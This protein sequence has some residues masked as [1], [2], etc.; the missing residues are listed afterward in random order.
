[1]RRR[2]LWLFAS[3]FLIISILLVSCGPKP[4]APAPAASTPAPITPAPVPAPTTT[5]AP[6]GLS[7]MAPS[8]QSE[9]PRYGGTINII[10]SLN[11]QIENWDSAAQPVGMTESSYLLHEQLIS[12]DW[13]KGPAGTGE[14]DWGSF[15]R[16]E[17]FGGQLAESWTIPQVGTWIFKIRKGVHYGL[18]PAS[19]ASKLVNGR[20]FTADDAVWGLRRYTTDPAY[21][22]ANV[23]RSQGVMAR[24]VTADKT[25]PW[26]VTLKTPVE[27][28]VAFFWVVWGGNSMHF[29]AREVI[30]K[31]GSGSDPRNAVGTGP[32]LVTDYIPGNMIAFTRNPNYWK[33]EP[34]G[35][36]K[37]MQLPYISTIKVFVVPDVSTRVAAMRTGKGDWV[38]AIEAEDAESLLKTSPELQYYRFLASGGGIA[39]RIEK[40]ELPFKDV[41]VRQ[42]LMMATDYETIKRDLYEG[43]AEILASP[44][45][46][47]Y[48]WLFVP[49]NKLSPNIQE[50]FKYNPEKAKQLLAEAGYPKGFKTK[51]LVRSTA[52]EMD[53]ASLIKAMWLKAGVDVE[54]QSRDATVYSSMGTA[55]SWEETQMGTFSSGGLMLTQIFSMGFK[56]T[57]IAGQ[58]IWEDP[59]ARKAYDEAQ[60]YVFVDMKK[61]DEI[62]RNIIPH[63]IEQATTIPLPVPY[64]YTIWQPWV[65]N[66]YGLSRFEYFSM[67]L[68]EAWIDQDLKEKMTGRR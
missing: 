21:P 15:Q 17:S 59:V 47:Y 29:F 60:K 41:K 26:E 12:P 27:P 19:E 43:Q 32:Y 54:I 35:P 36:G 1:M 45:P 64:S 11:S 18:N 51:M 28:W 5:P 39:M 68:Q 62:Q 66:V 53:K 3:L 58:T 61:Y 20:E 52:A 16:F 34:V 8:A 30:E 38:T 14:T 22:N 10:M 23:R 50:L 4:V 9:K 48:D 25:G 7:P 44:V 40:T 56:G 33:A 65:K 46:Y 13:A 6:V 49:M 31:Y 57:Y 67:W 24:A 55:R 63:A 37:G 2:V 42:A